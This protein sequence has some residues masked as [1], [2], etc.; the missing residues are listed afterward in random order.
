METLV[1]PVRY[2][3]SPHSLPG[4]YLTSHLHFLCRLVVRDYSSFAHTHT[5][6]PTRNTH[7][8]RT[9]TPSHACIHTTHTRHPYPIASELNMCV[10]CVCV[11]CMCDL[12][13]QNSL[14]RTSRR[15]KARVMVIKNSGRLL[16]RSGPRMRIRRW[17]ISRSSLRL[18]LFRA[19]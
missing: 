9:H 3:L 7:T 14:M 17:I 8:T 11:L 6:T 19:F 5:S 10:R 12:K 4:E 18:S 2:S 15:K 1:I 16:A 13:Q